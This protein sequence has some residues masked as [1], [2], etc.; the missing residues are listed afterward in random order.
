[1][2]RVLLPK[3]WCFFVMV[4]NPRKSGYWKYRRPIGLYKLTN[5]LD[6]RIDLIFVSFTVWI[7][8]I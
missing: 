1:M 6:W 7:E 4:D 5:W 8:K 3:S 2:K